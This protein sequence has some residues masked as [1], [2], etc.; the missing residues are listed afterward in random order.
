V[1]DDSL[2]IFVYLHHNGMSHLKVCI[3]C[4]SHFAQPYV[5]ISSKGIN[6]LIVCYMFECNI[7][8]LYSFFWVIF[9]P[10]NFICRRFR[11]LCSIF[12]RR[13]YRKNSCS[14]H[15][16]RWNSVPKRRHLKFRG[17]DITQVKEYN[18]YN[19]A[20]VWNQK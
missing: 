16:W 15:L 6:L 19:T 3:T 9:R 14:H 1:A 4:K 10:L 5:R 12:I 2:L 18:I 11:T 7:Q 17:R 20:K 8:L 13:A